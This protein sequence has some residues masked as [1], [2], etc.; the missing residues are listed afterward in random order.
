MS[1]LIEDYLKEKINLDM[2]DQDINLK[3]NEI[4]SL[5]NQTKKEFQKDLFLNAKIILKDLEFNPQCYGK[6]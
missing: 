1:F 5:I 2:G 6:T 4:E 3:F